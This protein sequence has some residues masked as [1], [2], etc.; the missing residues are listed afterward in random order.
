LV[1]RVVHRLLLFYVICFIIEVF[2]IEFSEVP[3]QILVNDFVP[4]LSGMQLGE[5]EL[6]SVHV[7]SALGG[8]DAE[9]GEVSAV[10]SLQ[11]F[12]HGS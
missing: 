3:D 11:G 7:Q 4:D 8:L 12:S 2:R 9:P 5:L 10:S 6:D 1:V